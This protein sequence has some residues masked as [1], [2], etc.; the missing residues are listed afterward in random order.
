MRSIFRVGDGGGGWFGPPPE[1]P[2]LRSD[3]STS[4]QGGGAEVRAHYATSVFLNNS[5]NTGK[6]SAG[7]DI[8][9]VAK[10]FQPSATVR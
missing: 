10:F 9:L 4:P 6:M 3:V 5:R 8:R 2:P 7:F 1:T